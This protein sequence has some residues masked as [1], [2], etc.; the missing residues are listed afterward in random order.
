MP[1]NREVA[2]ISGPG[3]GVHTEHQQTLINPS[4]AERRQGN[5]QQG[6][7]EGRCI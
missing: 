2:G 6:K 7:G 3:D 1:A 4:F 5:G